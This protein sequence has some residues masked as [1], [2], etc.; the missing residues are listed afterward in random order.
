M[1]R[2]RRL[3]KLEEIRAAQVD[4]ANSQVLSLRS[5]VKTAQATAKIIDG[6]IALQETRHKSAAILLEKT[7][8]RA[9]FAGIVVDKGAEQ[10]EVV[11]ATGAGGNS[12]GSVATLVD[13]ST[14]EVQIELPETRLMGLTEGKGA[15]IFL[16]VDPSKS[17][18]GKIRQIWP[19]ADRGKGTVE[20]RVVFSQRPEVLRPEMGVRI[21]FDADDSSRP[22]NLI[23]IPKSALCGS[24]AASYVFLVVAVKQETNRRS[25]Q[26]QW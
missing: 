2:V 7:Y 15:S 18:P 9:P 16:D 5:D 17:W 22:E 8:V 19:T 4:G 24:G 26:N 20:L 12:R 25:R 1:T 3:Q 14:L 13:L 21:V 11:A 6:E 10:G 23:A